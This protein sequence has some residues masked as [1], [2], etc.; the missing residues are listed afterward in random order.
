M[1]VSLALIMSCSERVELPQHD[2]PPHLNDN[3]P[4]EEQVPEQKP[5]EDGKDDDKKDE[6]E[7]REVSVRICS[8]NVG[9]FSKSMQKLGHYS[10][11]EAAALLKELKV[12][13][14]GLNETDKGNSRTDN[15]Y[16]AEELAKELGEGW[17]SYFAYA[18]NLYY[19]N[20]IVAAPE[21][22][23]VKEW[24]RL[25]IPRTSGSENRSMGAVEYEDFVFCVTHLDHES[26]DDRKNGVELIT[27]WA[28]ENYGA[29]QTS[30]PVF[31]VGDMN[32]IS[33]EVTI[34]NF[35]KNWNL[36]SAKENTFPSD[37]PTRCIDYIFVLNNGIEYK[38]GES[39]AV[40]T[41]DNVSLISDHCP[42][43]CD[44]TYEIHN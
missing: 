29:G 33:S 15:H 20:S 26:V 2:T 1:L 6:N 4:E 21:Y 14:A 41:P 22:K 36:I 10:Y 11:P 28:I 3:E 27:A 25:L 23:V 44:I 30:K 17:T 40:S 38:V 42:I 5:E 43:Y 32:C 35:K 34:S 24:P 31:L 37:K 18:H 16:Q 8:Y 9:T 39:H 12:D 13:V 19:G 7:V